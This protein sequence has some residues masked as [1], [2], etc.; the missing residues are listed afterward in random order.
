[1]ATELNKIEKAKIIKNIKRGTDKIPTGKAVLFNIILAIVLIFFMFPIIWMIIISFKTQNQIVSW[2]PD[3][4]SKFTIENYRLIFNI[5][6]NQLLQDPSRAAL[7][8]DKANNFLKSLLTTGIISIFSV[9]ISAIIGIPAAYGLARYKNKN[10]EQLAFIFLSFRFVPELLVI[11]PLY[12]I[13]QKVQLYD[14]YFGLIWVY[15]LISLPMIIWINRTYFDDMPIE[16][17]Q[18]AMLDGYPKWKIFTKIILPLAKPGIAASV[19]LSFIYA[20]NNLVFGLILSSSSKQPITSTI[21]AFWTIQDLNYGK[22]A[23]AIT[24]AIIPMVIV[25]QIASKYLVSGLSM[26]AIKK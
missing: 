21:I 7:M 6:I 8:I 1:M 18:A 4:F 3:I 22:I 9:L 14:T 11:I 5:N 20:W 12:L 24:V 13:Y 2:P 23:A 26:G 10:K 16:L 25:S 19:V 17:E 15:L